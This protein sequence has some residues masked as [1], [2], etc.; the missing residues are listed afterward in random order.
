MDKGVHTFPKGISPKENKIGQL[1][2][3]EALY[4]A[5]RHVGHY[6]MGTLP[7]FEYIYI[8]IYIYI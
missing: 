1:V 2:F 5:L 3:E 4:V 8:Y 6:T 7:N